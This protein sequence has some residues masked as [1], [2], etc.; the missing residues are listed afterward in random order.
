MSQKVAFLSFNPL[1]HWSGPENIAEI[2]IDGESSWV[3]LDSGLTINVVTSEFVKVCSLD[4]GPLSDLADGTM[5]INVFGGVLS[6]P[7]AMMR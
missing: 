3:L 5:G 4:I 2:R 6:W 7:W 1:T